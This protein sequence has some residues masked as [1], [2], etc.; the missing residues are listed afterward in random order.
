MALAWA[1][2][3]SLLVLATLVSAGALSWL[4]QWS[5]SHLM[6]YMD[7]PV[8]PQ[9]LW[10]RVMSPVG[11]VGRPTNTLP[12]K[13][14]FAL[15]LPAAPLA[16]AVIAAAGLAALARRSR[17][18]ALA[19]AV[20]LVAATLAEVVM[21]SVIERPPLYRFDPHRHAVVAKSAFT[22]SFPSGHTVRA[23]LLA[24][25]LVEL[26]PCLAPGAAAW[27]AAMSVALVAT[28]MHTPTDVAGG[29]LL[30]AV[31]VAALPATWL[32]CRRR[33]PLTPRAM[34]PPAR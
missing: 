23:V 17:E 22:D 6:P 9:S 16:T 10:E 7:R 21:K 34:W 14:L 1:A 2:A 30:G 5:V 13:L 25:L 31:A 8:R 20:A 29:L 19:W 4:D 18:R 3:A 12:A 24:A 33:H 28:S 26:V 11:A 32:P 27:V 15:T